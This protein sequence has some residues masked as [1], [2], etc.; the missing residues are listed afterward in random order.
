LQPHAQNKRQH[1]QKQKQQRLQPP[2][3]SCSR[4]AQQW[5]SAPQTP[6]FVQWYSA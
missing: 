6:T 4:H 5:K 3:K 2:K 1:A